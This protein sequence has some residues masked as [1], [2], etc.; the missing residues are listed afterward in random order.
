MNN[1]D[2]KIGF[3]A[4]EWKGVPLERWDHMKDSLIYM[5]NSQKMIYPQ[6]D[7]ARMVVKKRTLIE[8]IKYR[9][10]HAWYALK[11]GECD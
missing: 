10:S 3:T 1:K 2:D 6:W 11:G 5:M 4:Y 7:P 9:L 8:E